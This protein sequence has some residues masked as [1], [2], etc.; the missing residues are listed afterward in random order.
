V[1]LLVRHGETAP[2]VDGLLLGRADPP[3]TERGE[4]QARALATVLPQPDV[5]V[6]SP[7]GRALATA[8]AFSHD[9]E[10]DERWTEL[11][12]GGFDGLHPSEVPADLWLRWRS[13]PSF[14]PP[15]AESLEQLGRRVRA[16]CT[17][18]AAHAAGSVVVVVS[19]VSPIKSAIAWALGCGEEIASRMFV[20]NASVARIDVERT[21]PVL[22]WFNR[23]PLEVP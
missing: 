6:S 2:N 8:A 19:H 13:D 4:G 17:D 22:R 20:E 3:L 5:L 9:V 21:G 7:L 15:G 16:A 18:L 1:L 10:V 23:G 12:Y 14:A 11:D